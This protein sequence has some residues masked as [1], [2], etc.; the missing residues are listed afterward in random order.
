MAV[1]REGDV[2][3]DDVGSHGYRALDGVH[4][5]FGGVAPVAAMH[6]HEDVVSVLAVEEFAQLLGAGLFGGCAERHEGR[7][8]GQGE[9]FHF[10]YM[11]LVVSEILYHTSAEIQPLAQANDAF[12]R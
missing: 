5:V 3:F 12:T 8:R 1:L 2:E 9:Y 6:R 7:D 11:F 4:G 10:H